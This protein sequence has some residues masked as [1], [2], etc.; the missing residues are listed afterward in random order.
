[1]TFPE[2][3]PCLYSVFLPPGSLLRTPVLGSLVAEQERS[4]VFLVLSVLTILK[5]KKGK[6]KEDEELDP[7]EA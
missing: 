1:M 7:R 5:A 3:A 4:S 2:D 6:V